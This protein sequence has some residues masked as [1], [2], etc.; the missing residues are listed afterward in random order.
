MS[1][2]EVLVATTIASS[3]TLVGSTLLLTT[4][5]QSYELMQ[6]IELIQTLYQTLFMLKT[7]MRRAGYNPGVGA[8][9]TLD[10]AAK[11]LETGDDWLDFMTVSPQGDWYKTR[12]QRDSGT[13]AVDLCI[14]R[15][16][17]HHTKPALGNC[18]G[19]FYSVF[20]ENQLTLSEF[21]VSQNAIAGQRSSLVSVQMSLS[22]ADGMSN[23]SQMMMVKQRNWQ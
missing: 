13:E 17:I 19:H 8:S 9:S 18:T 11:V 3:V 10:G 5:K 6:R 12:Y 22:T 1:L 2:V 20:D 21:S 15:V 4:Q 16:S 14:Q 23:L 7:E